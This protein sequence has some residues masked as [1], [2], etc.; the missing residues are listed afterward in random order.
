MPRPSSKWLSSEEG[1][2][3]RLPTEA[4][5]EYACRAGTETPFSFG[6]CLSTDQANY[7]GNYPLDGCRKGQYPGE[8]VTV[9]SFGANAWGLHDMHGNV[10]AWYQDW[11]GDY[12]TAAVTDPIGPSLGA[13]WVHRG[14]SWDDGARGCRSAYRNRASPGYR[15]GK[16]CFCL[17]RTP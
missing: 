7:N 4:E 6:R 16:L 1:Q 5:W 2:T 17:A 14:G 11:Y 9:G 13:R 15:Y 3:N 8:P 10:W 12:P